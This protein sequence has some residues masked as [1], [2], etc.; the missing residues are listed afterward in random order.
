MKMYKIGNPNKIRI[1]NIEIRL[2]KEVIDIGKHTPKKSILIT[3]SYF[4]LNLRNVNELKKE[5]PHTYEFLM[6]V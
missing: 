6:K 1:L 4:R 5:S 2:N 3:H